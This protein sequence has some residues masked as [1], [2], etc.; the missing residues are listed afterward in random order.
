[1]KTSNITVGQDLCIIANSCF[2]EVQS[3]FDKVRSV[4][5][6]LGSV[7]LACATQSCLVTVTVAHGVNFI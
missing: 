7:W 4:A 1:M 3:E 5:F 6:L 2:G